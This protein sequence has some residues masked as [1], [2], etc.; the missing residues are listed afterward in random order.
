MNPLQNEVSAAFH[1]GV[2]IKPC[3]RAKKESSSS[4][5]DASGSD[6]ASFAI[7]CSRIIGKHKNSED[8]RFFRL[9]NGVQDNVI[10]LEIKHFLFCLF[11]LGNGAIP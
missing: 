2:V 11:F 1:T 5:T 7:T 9:I 8:E 10:F 3:H 6:V 4:C